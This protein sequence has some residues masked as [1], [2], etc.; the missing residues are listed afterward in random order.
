LPGLDPNGGMVVG[1][2]ELQLG[3]YLTAMFINTVN[4]TVI[5]Y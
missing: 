4:I 1:D 2:W 5:G 3:F